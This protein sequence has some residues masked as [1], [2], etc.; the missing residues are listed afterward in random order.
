MMNNEIIKNIESLA[1]DISKQINC[2][3]SNINSS[4]PIIFGM[5]ERYL[6]INPLDD[7]WI[8]RDRFLVTGSNMSSLYATL[9][10]AGYKF[11]TDE[12]KNKFYEI[13]SGIDYY[14]HI[15]SDVIGVGVGI[16]YGERYLNNLFYK[17]IGNHMVDFYT[18]ILISASDLINGLSYESF[19]FAGSQ[20]LNKLI[21]IYDANT[22][23]KD[24]I[25]K[26]SFN[27]DVSMYFKSMG[28]YTQTVI[29][30]GTYNDL[31]RAMKNIKRNSLGPNFIEIKNN[32]VNEISNISHNFF[33][34]EDSKELLANSIRKR[35]STY[36][37]DW[38][39]NETDTKKFDEI[40]NSKFT[41]NNYEVSNQNNIWNENN[42]IILS[43]SKEN[44]L[45]IGGSNYP[46]LLNNQL[47]I[48]TPS[49][50]L[51]QSIY[52]STRVEAM[53]F[54][55]I[56][57]STLGLKVYNCSLLNDLDYLKLSIKENV[58]N[59]E[60]VNYLFYDYDYNKMMTV[61]AI[62]SLRSIDNINV[63]RP[64]NSDELLM[65][66]NYIIDNNGVNSIII[67]NKPIINTSC[68][69]TKIINGGYIIS[70]YKNKMDAVIISSGS[71][72]SYALKVQAKLLE[73][74]I[75]VRI[76]SIPCLELFLNS[77]SFYQNDIIPI[78]VK[79]YVIEQSNSDIWYRYVYNSNQL[80][81]SLTL[82]KINNSE[83][84]DYITKK[85]MDDIDN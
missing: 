36:Y 63:F 7:S 14:H 85:I 10:Y 26:S 31:D 8:N 70:E 48:N 43:L 2:G 51:N 33:V 20:K 13:T 55:S 47:K 27:I 32:C 21:I 5:Y 17:K 81:N 12:L 39:N 1:V 45:F 4:V 29:S 80:F 23:K 59:K 53:G 76:V 83:I 52:Y 73:N 64:Y 46:I 58:L 6:H 3:I 15:P 16:A 40:M 9:F 67:N 69:K 50:P 65:T 68:D 71:D 34:N 62:S 30:D 56:G 57:L 44:L 11:S 38:I 41:L 61:D 84:I 37:F 75:D 25:S 22:M 49:C 28:Y 74:N 78:T 60:N 18:Y 82:N 77:N 54:I 19:S 42:N 79:K 35:F 24:E 66:W 72:V